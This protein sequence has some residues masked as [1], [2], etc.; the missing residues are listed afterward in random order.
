MRLVALGLLATIAS[1][2]AV[3]GY[4]IVCKGQQPNPQ[5]KTVWVD[6]NNRKQVVDTLGSAWRTLRQQGIGG[7]AED[8]CWESFN[9]AKALHPSLGMNAGLA[10]SFLLR[11]N[12]SL[13]YVQ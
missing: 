13:Q 9:D 3:A 7:H 10:S 6:C 12:M 4:E 2:P 8:M 11:C 5:H 1:M